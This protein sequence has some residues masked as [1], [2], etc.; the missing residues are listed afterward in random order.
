MLSYPTAVDTGS[1]IDK[2]VAPPRV[3][4]VCNRRSSKQNVDG[5]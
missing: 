3:S 2:T 4:G 1:V 5:F